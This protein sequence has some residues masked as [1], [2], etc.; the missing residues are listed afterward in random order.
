MVHKFFCSQII[1]LGRLS[2]WGF[3]FFFSI[4]ALTLTPPH[5]IQSLL[6]LG[7]QVPECPVSGSALL[8]ENDWSFGFSKTPNKSAAHIKMFLK[9]DFYYYLVAKFVSSVTQ[10]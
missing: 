2:Y 4:L 6:S 7:I 3:F 9:C 10:S 5:L 8:L 1:F